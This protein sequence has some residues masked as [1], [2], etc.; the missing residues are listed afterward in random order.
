MATV[1]HRSPITG[2]S[3]CDYG[4][5]WR[6]E[7]ALGDQVYP[8]IQ[9][10]LH[11]LANLQES[12]QQPGDHGKYF[13]LWVGKA[14]HWMFIKNKR[15]CCEL[16]VSSHNNNKFIFSIK[17]DFHWKPKQEHWAHQLP[18]Q[19]DCGQVLQ[20]SSYWVAQGHSHENWTSGL[21]LW[22]SCRLLDLLF[23]MC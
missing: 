19:S 21:S 22:R 13:P 8:F 17:S 7:A 1:R 6:R 3:H 4:Q 20:V 23:V 11:P 16:V 5:R 2:D 12:R 10:R 18:Q 15:R 14:N 9:Q